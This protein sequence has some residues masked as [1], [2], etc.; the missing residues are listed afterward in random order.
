MTERNNSNSHE[1]MNTLE[2]IRDYLAAIGG[3]L[4]ALLEEG[5]VSVIQVKTIDDILERLDKI[6]DEIS[7]RLVKQNRV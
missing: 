5:R 6:V 7:E 4:A 2:D 1:N 3:D